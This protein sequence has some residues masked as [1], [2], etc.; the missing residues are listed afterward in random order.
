MQAIARMPIVV[1]L[2]LMMIVP[3]GVLSDDAS[4]DIVPDF[5]LDL[6]QTIVHLK[7]ENNYNDTFILTVRN[8]CV[9]ALRIRVVIDGSGLQI[10]PQISTLTLPPYSQS[11]IEITA[12]TSEGADH[13]VRLILITAELTHADGVAMTG[14]DRGAQVLGYIHRQHDISMQVDPVEATRGDATEFEIVLTNNGNTVEYAT[15]NFLTNDDIGGYATVDI[16]PIPVGEYRKY[17]CVI[18]VPRDAPDD[19][20][21]LKFVVRSES[22]SDLR[23][24][25]SVEVLVEDSR[26]SRSNDGSGN[27]IIFLIGITFVLLF[28]LFLVSHPRYS[29]NRIT[30]IFLI[31]IIAMGS[32]LVSV[33]ETGSGQ[34]IPEI[35]VVVNPAQVVLNPSPFI[36]DGAA[37]GTTTVTI[38]SSEILDSAVRVTIDA[39]GYQFGYVHEHR[40]SAAQSATFEV[41]TAILKGEPYRVTSATVHIEIIEIEGVPVTGTSEAQAGFIIQSTPYSL[42][43]PTPH[44]PIASIEKDESITIDIEVQNLG[45]AVDTNTFSVTNKNDLEEYGIRIGNHTKEQDIDPS[46]STIV[47]I[48]IMQEE[49]L[50]DEFYLL[51]FE[52]SGWDGISFGSKIILVPDEIVGKDENESPT[53]HIDTIT[54]NPAEE[55]ETVELEGSGTDDGSIETYEW[56][57]S[58]DGE[59][60]SGPDSDISVSDLSVG[61]HTI[62]LRVQDDEGAWSSSVIEELDVIERTD[63]NTPPIVA[64]TLPTPG[65]NVTGTILIEGTAADDDGTVKEVELSLGGGPW[66]EVAGKETWRYVWTSETVS[67]G[68]YSISARSFDGTDHSEVVSVNITISNEP[69]TNDPG[70]E[71]DNLVPGIPMMCVVAVIGVAAI[72]HRRKEKQH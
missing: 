39:P 56:K 59:L 71:D 28:F 17:P 65:E 64:F 29:R 15:I 48:E 25:G 18:T 31:L 58:I 66:F 36:N 44:L 51:R 60:S 50:K 63:S 13:S 5:F 52:A 46:N 1:M 55:G 69:E 42:P 26:G 22:D 49:D 10:S 11:D 27:I 40:V 8:Q 38:S 30:S 3:L 24:D 9:H 21:P 32:T 4:G 53:A 14:K 23:I 12:A 61:E 33:P 41:G 37:T 67:N 68:P 6:D 54:P 57:S 45:N 7:E 2:T 16:L 34:I 35:D 20:E 47:S 43:I 62:S 70:G 72:I 19:P